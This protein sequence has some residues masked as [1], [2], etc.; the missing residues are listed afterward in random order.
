MCGKAF[1]QSSNLITHLRKHTGYRPFTCG[2][3]DKAFQRK[4]DLR[5]HRESQH[6]GSP[7]QQYHISSTTPTTA[8]SVSLLNASPATDNNCKTPP[9][10]TPLSEYS[11]AVVGADSVA[12]TAA[13]TTTTTTVV[14]ASSPQIWRGKYKFYVIFTRLRIHIRVTCYPLSEVNDYVSVTNAED[15][16]SKTAL[17]EYRTLRK[18]KILYF[19]RTSRYVKSPPPAPPPSSSS[20]SFHLTHDHDPLIY[21]RRAFKTTLIFII[22]VRCPRPVRTESAALFKKIRPPGSRF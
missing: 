14:V 20:S 22:I 8:S 3:C 12:T 2:L 7:S 5:R 21:I 16:P 4:V 9:P 15:A 10:Q 19:L 11:S 1:S 17:F 13:T 18:K 6:P